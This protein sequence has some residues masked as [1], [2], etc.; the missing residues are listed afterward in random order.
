L[1]TQDIGSVFLS[2]NMAV[3]KEI[4]PKLPLMDTNYLDQLRNE[5]QHSDCVWFFV[6]K[7]YRILAYNEA[8][9]QNSIRFH[10]KEIAPGHSILDYARDTNN[11][12]DSKFIECFGRA[13]SGQKVDDEQR[14][15]YDSITLMAKSSYTPVMQDNELKGVSITVD[16]TTV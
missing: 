10:N 7:K 4:T 8:A 15:L 13:A 1:Q 12:I 2:N 14:I 16:Y 5:Y 6:D 11:K 9:A 3:R